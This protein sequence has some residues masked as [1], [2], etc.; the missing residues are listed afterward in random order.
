MSHKRSL[1]RCKSICVFVSGYWKHALAVTEYSVMSLLI[2]TWVNKTW[3]RTLIDM[4]VMANFL[5]P[6]FARKMKILLQKK[7][8]VYAV[9]DIDEKLL[10]YN[11]EEIDQ[12]TEEIRLCI[13]SHMNDMQF[14]IT[15][16]GWHDV[17]LELLWLKDIDSKISFW[18]RMIDFSMRK[19]VHMSKEMSGS[20]LEICTI[21][22]D[23]L[24]KKIWEN[25]EQ[26]KILWTRQTNL[27]NT[28]F[29]NSISDEYWDFAELFAE[30]ASEKTF[31]AH[32]SWDHE[33]LIVEDKTLEKIVI[34]LLSSEKLEALWMYLDENLKKGFIRKSQSP[35]GY[36]I[37]F[38]SKKDRK[39]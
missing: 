13:R 21:S 8:D 3:T 15:L 33:I 28:T 5:S 29:M 6:E 38:V 24:K 7:S 26:V 23:N 34:Y 39:L 32:Q 2:W 17:V 9:T 18:C 31:S 4:S 12:K 35:A 16:T 36:S 22:A 1:N 11:E 14:D 27:I 25:S 19:L 37:L 10:R 20:G 30:E